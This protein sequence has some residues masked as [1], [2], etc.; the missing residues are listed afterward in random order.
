MPINLNMNEQIMSV[1]SIFTD[2]GEIYKLNFDYNK[3]VIENDGKSN[4][5]KSA[6]CCLQLYNLIGQEYLFEIE[7]KTKMNTELLYESTQ[8]LIELLSKFLI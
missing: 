8:Q 6:T 7:S 1:Q 2:G 5:L 4:K 3:I